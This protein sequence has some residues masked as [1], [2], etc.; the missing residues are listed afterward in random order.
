MEE[1]DPN[2]R[3]NTFILMDNYRVHKT[4]S[5][6]RWLSNMGVHTLF[7]APFSPVL[8]PIEHVFN[9]WKNPIRQKVIDTKEDLIDAIIENSPKVTPEECR[10]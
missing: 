5:I 9:K 8:N 6:T 1:E 4:E 3:D 10:K 7:T 2:F